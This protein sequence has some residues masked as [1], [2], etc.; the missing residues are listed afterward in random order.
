MNLCSYDHL[1]LRLVIFYFD[2]AASTQLL[3]LVSC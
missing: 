3:N 1:E 2:Y